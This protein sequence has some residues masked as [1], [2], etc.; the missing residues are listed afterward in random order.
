MNFSAF[1]DTF[2]QHRTQNPNARVQLGLSEG[3]GELPDPSLT[4]A[5]GRAQSARRLLASLT[6]LAREP[7]AFDDALDLD[8]ARLMLEA[9]LF[10]LSYEFNGQTTLHQQP[11]AGDE[12]GDGIFLMSVSD[13]RPAEQRLLDITRRIEGIPAYLDALIGRLERPVARW[14]QMDAAKVRELPTLLGSIESW[15][16]AERWHDAERVGRANAAARAALA[17]Y[18]RRLLALPSTPN[19]HVGDATAARIVALRGIEQSLDELHAMAKAFLAETNRQIESLRARLVD[20]YGLAADTSSADLQRFL[21]RRFR[22]AIAAG[23]LEQ[24]LVRYRQEHERVSRFIRER[25]LFPIPEHQSL[26]ILET[27]GFMR[28][29]IPAG[30]MTPPAPFRAGTATSLIFLTLSEELLDEHTELTIPIMM[31]HEGVP[32]HHLQLA[33]ASQHASRIRRHVMANDH[34]EGWTTML[35]D[36]MLDRGYAEALADEVR[37]CAKRDLCR[38]GARVAIDLFFMTGERDYLDLGL[39][40]ERGQPDPFAAAGELLQAVTGFTPGRVEAELNWYSSE[41]GYPL[42][43]LTGNQLVARLRR[44]LHAAQAERHSAERI[45]RMFFDRYLSSGNM[46]LAFLR[47]V[48][49]HEG[50]IPS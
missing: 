47:R 18:E 2:H 6:A 14:V 29:S 32:G 4:A 16:H 19:L 20:R 5:A 45:D 42:S 11:R 36:Y 24:V 38:I 46:P 22:V 27:P 26:E 34:A 33:T 21:N 13:P 41:R 37:F 17:D 30:A 23:G 35:E 3:L 31:V 40:L 44:D 15:A 9:E 8:L 50:L 1:V 39:G 25:D 48:F 7:L 43:Y 28:P 12:I 10:D 49:Q